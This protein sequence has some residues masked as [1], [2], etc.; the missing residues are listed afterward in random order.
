MMHI[1][2]NDRS[3]LDK[4]VAVIPKGH[5]DNPT[6]AT[7]TRTRR[8]Q[9]ERYPR[10]F[11]RQDVVLVSGTRS[12]KQYALYVTMTGFAGD[13]WILDILSP[14]QHSEVEDIAYRM[15]VNADQFEPAMKLIC[16]EGQ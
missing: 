3:D 12:G 2:I 6:G 15:R 9:L 14:E 7:A 16:Q 11:P 1:F 10:G 13:L 5:P 4:V 8:E